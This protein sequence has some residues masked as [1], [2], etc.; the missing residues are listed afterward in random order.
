MGKFL[1]EY[2]G[3]TVLTDMI[4]RLIPPN[5]YYPDCMC[6]LLLTKYH[7]YVLEDNFDGTYMEH[8]VF[9][10]LQIQKMEVQKYK[11]WES[12]KESDLSMILSTTLGII[13]NTVAIPSMS[14]ER[15]V[16]NKQFKI[17]YVNGTGGSDTL[18]FQDL[19]SGAAAM[20]MVFKKLQKQYR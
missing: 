19:Q 18:Y 14:R 1:K 20:E 15:V 2:K 10:V 6:F 17:T 12:V 9:P 8:F 16:R 5:N 3:E 7:L 11:I 13:I 4:A